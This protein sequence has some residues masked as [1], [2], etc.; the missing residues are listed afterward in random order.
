MPS[1]PCCQRKT[2][3]RAAY[4]DVLPRSIVERPKTPVA[5]FHEWLVAKW[6]A[7][8]RGRAEAGAVPGEWIDIDCWR[9]AL[10][11]GTANETMAAWRVLLLDRWLTAASKPE[12]L[13]IA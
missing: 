5:G 9:A 3:P 7:D 10:A 1:I 13:C 12:Q 6:R 4:A 8:S 11:G 2:L